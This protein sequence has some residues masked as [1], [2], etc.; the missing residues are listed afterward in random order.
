MAKK[1]TRRNNHEYS[2]EIIIKHY[3]KNKNQTLNYVF[4]V[5]IISWSHHFES[6]T[7]TTMT[8]L[9]AYHRLWSKGNT[10]GSFS[11]KCVVH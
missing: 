9:I 10:A 5:I 4:L 11:V 8:W 6:F 7:V 1:N 2:V 3:N